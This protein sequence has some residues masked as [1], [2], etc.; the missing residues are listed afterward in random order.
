MSL[1]LS[2]R[3]LLALAGTSALS[4]AGLG[5]TIA[6]AQTSASS[7]VFADASELAWAEPWAPMGSSFVGDLLTDSV[8][9]SGGKKGE[10]L[11]AYLPTPTSIDEVSA[12]I[13]KSLELDV[14]L[15]SDIGGGSSQ[16]AEGQMDY[17]VQMIALEE[18]TVG[19][20]A[21]LVNQQ[22]LTIF[23]SAVPDFASEM[24]SAQGA[25]TLNGVGIL[26]AVDGSSLQQDFERALA[27]AATGTST[28]GEYTD[29]TGSLVVTWINDWTAQGQ[30]DVGIELTDP[31]NSIVV[32]IQTVK[33]EGASPEQLADSDVAFLLDDQG[34]NASIT[35]PEFSDSGYSFA[36]N[37]E[38]GLRLV[39][40]T[41]TDNPELYVLTFAADFAQDADVLALLE[42]AQAAILINGNIPL[43]G[44]DAFI[45]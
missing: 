37:G 31:T 30:D 22:Q 28:G 3:T 9:L 35:G 26:Q 4:V 29:V 32:Y 42:E 1:N 15:V 2:R 33:I 23:V 13:F 10:V 14:S 44:L 45:A 19:Y 38:Y 18:G 41:L 34:S 20:Y 21:E 7:H 25:I 5:S 12:S 24:T 40:A 8:A 36:T 39:Q 11:V 17:R 27:N 16:G 6:R 43:D